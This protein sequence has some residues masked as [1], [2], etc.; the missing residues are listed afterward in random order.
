MESRKVSCMR[1]GDG[2][3]D[4]AGDSVEEAILRFSL[5]GDGDDVSEARAMYKLCMG[6][7][8]MR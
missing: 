7:Q 5:E 2:T 6:T 8:S 3:E 1:S 4:S